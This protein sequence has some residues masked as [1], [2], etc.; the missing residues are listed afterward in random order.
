MLTATPVLLQRPPNP[1]ACAQEGKSTW[2]GPVVSLE[3]QT[4]VTPE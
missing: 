1:T 2:A 3:L 4:Q